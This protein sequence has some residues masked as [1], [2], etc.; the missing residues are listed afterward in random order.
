MQLQSTTEHTDKKRKYRNSQSAVL[1]SWQNN[2]I[3]HDCTVAELL[4]VCC[5]RF[6]SRILKLVFMNETGENIV[7][8]NNKINISIFSECEK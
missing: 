2:I 7:N 5:Q 8:N 4:L 1:H 3:H 6:Q